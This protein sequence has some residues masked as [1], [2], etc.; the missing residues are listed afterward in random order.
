[1][2]PLKAAPPAADPCLGKLYSSSYMQK[3]GTVI[4][5]TAPDLASHLRKL[6]FPRPVPARRVPLRV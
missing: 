3:G 6:L 5:E 1:M 4:D 2:S